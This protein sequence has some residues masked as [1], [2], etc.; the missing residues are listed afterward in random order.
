MPDRLP[1]T[2][3]EPSVGEPSA[4]EPPGPSQEDDSPAPPPG[5]A[6]E[7][8]QRRSASGGRTVTVLGRDL[9]LATVALASM[10][11]QI[12]AFAIASA[13]T[14]YPL[15]ETAFRFDTTWFYR[16]AEHGYLHRAPTGPTDY[17]GLRIAFFPG[18]ALV[19]RAL[20][21]VVGG[22]PVHTT[23]LVGALGLIASCIAL[24]SLV[25]RDF[26]ESAAWRSVVLMAFFPG[27]YVFAMAYSEA[28]A[29]PLAVVTLWALR[30]RWFLMAGLAAALAGTMRL[31][32]L[33]LVAVCAVASARQLREEDRPLG[34]VVR[35]VVS[36]V[37][38]ATG[39]VGYLIY[40]KVT[41]GGFFTFATAEKL[42]WDDHLSF[43]ASFHQVRLFAE[44]GIHS[45]PLVIVNTMGLVVVIAAVVFVALVSMPLEYKVLAIGILASWLFTADH[46]AWFRYIEFAFPVLVA[47]AVKV[48]EKWL[49]PLVSACGVVLGLLIVLFATS[50]PFFP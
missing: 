50:T 5:A 34:T 15:A 36:P 3:V 24:W 7:R 47:I 46:G 35:A 27:A 9:G 19:E 8:R 44:H 21:V 17:G 43:T 14:R 29:L 12:L 18:L 23:L 33:V 6:P 1:T 30:R 16:I 41:T 38:A 20:H 45:T 42:G 28:L 40:L 31:D 4:A 26:D 13:I 48:P 49:L 10:L 32:S 39:V 11:V 37:L 2:A 22:G 25:A